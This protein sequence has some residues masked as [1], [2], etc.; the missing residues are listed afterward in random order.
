MEQLTFDTPGL[1][2]AIQ[3]MSA[4]D[5]DRLP[6]GVIGLDPDGLVRVFNGI[7]IF[8]QRPSLET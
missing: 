5:I 4:A 1:S 8:H 7:W 3:S 2:D 6:F